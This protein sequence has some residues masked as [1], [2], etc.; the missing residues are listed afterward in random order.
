MKSKL[1]VFKDNE[2]EITERIIGS[3]VKHF[4]LIHTGQDIVHHDAM[5]AISR[6]AK[7]REE[8]R[9]Y[10]QDTI[11]KTE[12]FFSNSKLAQDYTDHQCDLIL[13]IYRDYSKTKES[14]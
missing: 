4:V 10:L 14:K 3:V 2:K 7:L 5:K 12:T 8:F 13:S 11:K 1:K 6:T 9:V